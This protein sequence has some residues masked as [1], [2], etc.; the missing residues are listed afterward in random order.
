MNRYQV[1]ILTSDILANSD[2]ANDVA[3]FVTA[4]G[5]IEEDIKP[6]PSFSD[7]RELKVSI[8][9]DEKTECIERLENI[10]S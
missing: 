9:E 1:G 2:N 6:D 8:C 10:V 5:G 4:S 3:L 7:Q